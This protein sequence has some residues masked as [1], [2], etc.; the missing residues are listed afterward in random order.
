MYNPNKVDDEAVKTTA[1]VKLK[2][3]SISIDRFEEPSDVDVFVA[4]LAKRL[5]WAPALPENMAFR[6][7]SAIHAVS[8]MKK[9]VPLVNAFELLH[10]LFVLQTT[11]GAGGA[12]LVGTKV[13]FDPSELKNVDS[14]PSLGSE[15][16]FIMA[17]NLNLDQV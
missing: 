8:K 15:L 12:N 7:R 11:M 9:S 17:S 6:A 1:L 13:A 5:V 3:V 4:F 2:D 14:L 10:D 16:S